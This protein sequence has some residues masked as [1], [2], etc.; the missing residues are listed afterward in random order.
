[1][2]KLIAALVAMAVLSVLLLSACSARAPY[3]D[4]GL[5][6]IVVHNNERHDARVRIFCGNGLAKRLYVDAMSTQRASIPVQRCPDITVGASFIANAIR[7]RVSHTERANLD[8]AMLEVT[9]PRGLETVFLAVY[10]R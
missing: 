6:P 5:V 7:P 3:P 4:D 8:G 2:R 10:P 9:V 1:M